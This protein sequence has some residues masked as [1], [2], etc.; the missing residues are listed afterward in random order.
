[1][2]PGT[3]VVKPSL[4]SVSTGVAPV[5]AVRAVAPPSRGF[6]LAWLRSVARYFLA[7]RRR[8]EELARIARLHGIVIDR[9]DSGLSILRP[10]FARVARSI[11][12][13][14]RTGSLLIGLTVHE[15][16]EC[17]IDQ[18]ANLARYAPEAS[19]VVHLAKALRRQLGAEAVELARRIADAHPSAMIN[20]RSFETVYASGSL[21]QAQV[22]NWL[23]ARER[24]SFARFVLMSSNELLVRCGIERHLSSVDLAVSFNPIDVPGAIGGMWRSRI[25]RGAII[26]DPIFSQFVGRSP[27]RPMVQGIHEGLCM[28]AELWDEF[29]RAFDLEFP[30][31]EV[32]YPTEE[33]YLHNLLEPV[34][35][36]LRVV[37][38]TCERRLQGAAA[39]LVEEIGSGKQPHVFSI[40]RVA[41]RIDDPIRRMIRERALGAAP[42]E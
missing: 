40:K 15:S 6:G 5:P 42:V 10:D 30:H 3:D 38:P 35:T 28:R 21:L 41:R 17:V 25:R 18:V 24:G 27:G 12:G 22:S 4:A 20:P 7:R 32:M 29:A 13:T 11:A 14:E 34:V 9:L 23:V 16:P 33:I 36:M 26:G 37:P 8:G 1:M 19:V 2:T 39:D 31:H